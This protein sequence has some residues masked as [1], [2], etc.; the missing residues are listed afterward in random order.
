[1]GGALIPLLAIGLPGSGATAVILAAFMLKGVQ[2][3]PQIFATQAA[4]VYTIFASVFLGLVL[5]AVIGYFAVRPLVRILGF[6]EAVIS[7]FIVIICAI[8]AL[9]IRNNIVDLWLMLG[10]GGLGYLLDRFRFPVAPLV[11]GC[12]LGPLAEESFMNAMIAN[13]NDI[14]VFF[15]RPIAATVMALTAVTIVAG[16][17]AG[18]RRDPA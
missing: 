18:S 2:P 1:V 3:G 16:L 7:A 11:L 13:N 15:R 8:G 14:T 17:V 4:M 5:M 9:S 6:P 12:I 10:F